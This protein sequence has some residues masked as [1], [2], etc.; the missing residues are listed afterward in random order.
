MASAN[1]PLLLILVDFIQGPCVMTVRVIRFEFADM[2]KRVY[3]YHI[4][5]DDGG[6]YQP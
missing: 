6:I 3:V 4:E 5:I 2:V 1:G